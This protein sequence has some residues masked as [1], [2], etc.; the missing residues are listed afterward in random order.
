[1]EHNFWGKLASK[2]LRKSFDVPIKILNSAN[3]GRRL[4]SVGRFTYGHD[5]ISVEQ[6]GEGAPLSIG[7][8]CSIAGDVKIFL[9]GNHRADW[10]TTFPF[11][12]IYESVFFWAEILLGDWIIEVAIDKKT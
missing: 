10:I 5:S 1:M 7:A 8:F 4:F 9:G 11:G 12:H 6:W 2:F 3:I